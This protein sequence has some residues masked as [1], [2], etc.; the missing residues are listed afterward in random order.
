MGGKAKLIVFEHDLS[1]LQNQQSRHPILCEV[2]EEIVSPPVAFKGDR[3]QPAL[4][5][6]EPLRSLTPQH[7][8]VG[9]E[10][11]A[12]LESPYLFIRPHV[13]IEHRADVR[14][15]SLTF[16]AALPQQANQRKH[17]AS[18]AEDSTNLRRVPEPIHSFILSKPHGIEDR[19]R[20]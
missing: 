11:F 3:F 20:L 15:G 13:S 14:C 16:G 12:P 18:K 4:T 1:V 5:I 6:G 10:P 9:V 19:T 7:A 8:P 2:V 17:C